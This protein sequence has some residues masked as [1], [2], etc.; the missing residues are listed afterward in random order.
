MQVNNQSDRRLIQEYL[1]GD[2]KSLEILIHQYLG[3]VYRFIYRITGSRQD[4]EDITQ[5]V[6]VKAWKNLK[7]FDPEKNFKTWLFAIAKNTSID[8]LRKK[9]NFAFSDFDTAEGD[10]LLIDI[11]QDPAPLPDS[12]IQMSEN[13][14]LLDC[15]LEQLSPQYRAVLFL[16]YN[17]HFTLEEI[18][19]VLG[20]PLDTVK[21]QHRRALIKLREILNYHALPVTPW[22]K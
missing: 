11:L 15:A 13:K 19:Q 18:G 10:N 6:F 14:K 9:K 7:R 16:R 5:E 8:W 20:K 3:P 21:S 1:A 22:L 12:L 4:A 2:D 17:D